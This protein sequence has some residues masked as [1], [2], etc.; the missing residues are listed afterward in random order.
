LS[1]SSGTG[2]SLTLITPTFSKT[3]AFIMLAI[4]STP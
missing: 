1:P 2:T 4:K 3:A